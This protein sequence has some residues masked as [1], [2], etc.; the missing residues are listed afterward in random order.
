YEQFRRHAERLHQREGQPS[1]EVDF[2]SYMPQY[3]QLNREQGNYYLWW[4][5]N[6]RNGVC[7]P[8]AYSYLLL[9]LYELI[10]LDESF[11]SPRTGQENMLRL[12]F[13]YRDQHPRLD[14]LIREW[15]CDYSL[16]H[17]RPPPRLDPGQYRTLLTGCRLK[18]FYV[19]A[20][21]E[22][23]ALKNAMLLF[24]NN[25]D[26]TKSKFYNEE[27]KADYDRVLR[28]AVDE[29]VRFLRESSGEQLTD[30]TGVSTV[31]R[32]AFAG[33]ICSYRLKRRIEVD[34]TSFSHTH[35]LRY[36]MTDVL[37]YAE[38]ALRQS[39]G[40][41]S[42]LSIYSVSV[43]LRQRLDA[44]LAGVL[45]KKQSRAAQSREIPDYERH[46]DLPVTELS[47]ERAAAIEAESWQTTKRLVEAFAGE[48][49]EI[50]PQTVREKPASAPEPPPAA[51]VQP[52]PV[53]PSTAA[54]LSP[55]AEALGDLAAFLPLARSGDRAAQR[56]FA[57]SRGLMVDAIA[58]K[59]NTVTGDI[60]GDI[61]LEQ[62]GDAYVIIEDYLDFLT[63]QG[64]L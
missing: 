20:D 10:N 3:S 44:Y 28:G 13:S 43:P 41:K 38:N 16:L 21:D 48:E 19:P 62:E 58:D 34:Y 26:Y 53:T 25:Y 2:F 54:A 6:F 7:L 61:V 36:V 18:E 52:L 37:K 46:Y 56:E 55:L 35:E 57:R 1:P 30:A 14:A 32:D 22:G 9:Y 64:V 24:C 42:R 39:R 11:I 5:T 27:T 31:S 29:T 15:L 51:P 8:A 49:T 47:P 17:E 40:I 23:D 12:W 45:P 33:A 4:R 63:D 59:I 60:L 50:T